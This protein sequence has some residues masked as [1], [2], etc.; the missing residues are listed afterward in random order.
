[1]VA[2]FAVALFAGSFLLFV[3]QPMCARMLLPLLGGGPGV[4]NTCMVFFQFGLLAGYAYAH[5]L[6]GRMGVRRHALPHL[7]LMLL[8]FVVLPIQFQE[9]PVEGM[10]VVWLLKVLWI[11]AGLPYV[12][13][14]AGAPLL[15]KWYSATGHARAADPYYLYAASNVGSLL[16]LG[17]YPFLVEP[18]LSLSEQSSY[19]TAGYG[20]LV[21]LTTVCAYLLWRTRDAGPTDLGPMESGRAGNMPTPD[22]STRARWIA[23]AL[24]PSS[25]V[26]S[27]TTFLTMDIAAMPLLWVAPLGIY[28][29]T[30]ILVFARKTLLP[31][32]LFLR[33]LPL[34][35]LIL[36]LIILR[37]VNDP[38]LVVMVMHLAGLFWVAMACHGELVRTR[39][40]AGH[41]TE[42]Y[43]WLALGGV[44]GGMVNALAGPVL[45][46]SLAEYPLMLAGAGLLLLRSEKKANTAQRNVRRWP[47]FIGSP[48][49]LDFACPAGIAVVA[50]GL[51][52]GVRHWELESKPLGMVLFPSA[53]LLLCYLAKDRPLRFALA[54]G[55][56][57]LA[58]NFSPGMYGLV[59]YRTRSFFGVY[60]VT[61]DDDNN[62][63]K[64]INGSTVHGVQS[65]DPERQGIPLSYYHPAGPIGDVMSMLK[66]D[67]RLERVALVGLGTGTL[68]AY[69]NTGQHWT[70]FEIDPT[71]VYVARDSGLFTYLK[72]AP[73]RIEVVLGD[74]R[75]KLAESHERFGLIILD[76]FNSDAIPTHLLTQ[77]ALKIFRDRLRPNGLLVYHISNRYLDL[78]PVLANLADEATP[79]MECII[80][81]DQRPTPSEGKSQSDWV[82]LTDRTE[83]VEK[84]LQL[85]GWRHAHIDPSL[86]PWTDDYSSLLDVLRP[87][88]F[89]ILRHR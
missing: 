86:P 4:W 46:K 82:I 47:A 76:A 29:L 43:F 28:L 54:L 56:V 13:T 27:V 83:N 61:R 32:A 62:L 25:L 87:E 81:E 63:R 89:S 66:G 14:S 7:V 71:I 22:W 36:A 51:I 44:L 70:F 58:G 16:A 23:L 34:V 19:W 35:I 24:V 37:E 75:L 45:F 26:L 55:A 60:R 42:Y 52:F 20:L 74:G 48:V 65:L 78:E 88:V 85:S 3:V 10:P 67:A 15:Q 73:G 84:L 5:A 2:S 68:A 6:P 41:L 38:V 80:R 18:N 77:E 12:V 59:E 64:L 21:G 33:G 1:L 31:H 40:G 49:L 11:G 79:F 50:L 9:K 69:S 53:A 17:S 39:P 30:F 57:F 72:N 8:P